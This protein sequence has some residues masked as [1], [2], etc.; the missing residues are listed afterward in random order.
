MKTV[1]LKNN[2][3]NTECK[4]KMKKDQNILTRSQMRRV[5]QV[6]CGKSDCNCG[7]V[8]GPQDFDFEYTLDRETSFDRD[9]ETIEIQE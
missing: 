8:R 5:N 7:A 6:L 4:V 9:F 3:H 1:T 2:F